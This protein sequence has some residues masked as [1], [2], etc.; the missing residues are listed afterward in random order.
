M[1]FILFPSF[2]VFSLFHSPLALLHSSLGVRICVCVCMYRFDVCIINALTKTTTPTNGWPTIEKTTTTT[3]RTRSL[4]LAPH[5]RFHRKICNNDVLG[6]SR[7]F[8]VATDGSKWLKYACKHTYAIRYDAIQS[9]RI[10]SQWT[11]S[12]QRMEHHR[13][14]AGVH[15]YQCHT[16]HL[17]MHVYLLNPHI[18][19]NET[20]RTEKKRTTNEPTNTNTV[21]PMIFVPNQVLTIIVFLILSTFKCN[22]LFSPFFFFF[23][24]KKLTPSTASRSPSRYW[25][26]NWLQHR[27]T[28]KVH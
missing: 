3:T 12:Y 21:S 23:W 2:Y 18:H 13:N 6:F 11:N 28:S 16:H 17:C 14:T 10:T 7:I 27:S 20:P 1:S 19:P 4:S 9:K 5:P 24:Q 15:T 26:Y 25:C 22:S 8:R